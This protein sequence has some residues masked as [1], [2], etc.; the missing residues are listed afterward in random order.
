MPPPAIPDPSIAVRIPGDRPVA[1]V[2]NAEGTPIV[3]QPPVI[4][5]PEVIDDPWTLARALP[6]LIAGLLIGGS[7]AAILLRRHR[8]RLFL[9]RESDT[10][11][12]DAD[13]PQVLVRKQGAQ[14]V[15]RG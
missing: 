5:P 2:P 15:R 9:V 12:A 7:L 3:V 1:V 10:A 11:A 4:E 14:P 8:R 6:W 13:R